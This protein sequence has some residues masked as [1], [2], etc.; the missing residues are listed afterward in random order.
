MRVLY[1]G[2]ALTFN[3]PVYIGHDET[4]KLYCIQKCPRIQRMMCFFVQF[5]SGFS[6]INRITYPAKVLLANKNYVVPYFDFANESVLNIFIYWHF[7]MH[8]MGTERVDSFLEFIQTSS[9][10][11]FDRTPIWKGKLYAWMY[12]FVS[13]YLSFH[14]TRVVHG[15]DLYSLNGI[16]VTGKVTAQALFWIDDINDVPPM[17]GIL[18]FLARTYNVMYH[19][20]VLITFT[21]VT[22]LTVLLIVTDFYDSI[23]SYNLSIDEVLKNYE[24][25][26]ELIDRANAYCSTYLFYYMA[27][28]LTFNSVHLFDTLNTTDFWF[29]I[30]MY[31]Y[32][33]DIWFKLWSSAKILIHAKKMK[34]WLW[35]DCNYLRIPRQQLSLT[36]HDM[37][38][39]MPRRGLRAGKYLVVSSEFAGTVVANMCSYS[40]FVSVSAKHKISY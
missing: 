5:I 16:L 9:L 17:L 2:G 35:K 27:M 12:W 26:K 36:L 28:A 29:K 14:W 7:Y 38:P 34:K 23:L 22:M 13:L 3:I 1:L 31:I 4:R 33:V 21:P 20:T 37:I 11:R 18:A 30:S 8:W 24:E 25:Y 19:H 32:D 40:L 15:I 10:L 39:W 6:I